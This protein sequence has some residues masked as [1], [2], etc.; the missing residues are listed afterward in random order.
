MI[1]RE[2]EKNLPRNYP[3]VGVPAVGCGRSRKSARRNQQERETERERE[4]ERMGRRDECRGEEGRRRLEKERSKAE[5]PTQIRETRKLG[6]SIS[7]R[8]EGSSGTR[9]T[10][11]LLLLLLVYL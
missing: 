8:K 5:I 6:S 7:R 1:R 4:K 9:T 3:R 10:A 2:R 11:R